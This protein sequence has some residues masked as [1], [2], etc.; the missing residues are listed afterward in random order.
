MYKDIKSI[1]TKI[2]IPCIFYGNLFFFKF[3]KLQM[4]SDKKKAQKN[5]MPYI[6]IEEIKT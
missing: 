4:W 6:S 3:C 5:R 2:Y 1:W